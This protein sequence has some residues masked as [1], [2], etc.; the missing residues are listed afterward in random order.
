MPPQGESTGI[1]IEDAIVFSRAMINHKEHPFQKIFGAY[2]D[3]RRSHIDAAYTQAVQRWETVKDSGSLVYKMKTLL[4]PWILWWT[5]K[6]REDEFSV[7]YTDYD[8]KL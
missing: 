7:D 8:F 3:F 4:T 5:A 2:E 1:C 6:A